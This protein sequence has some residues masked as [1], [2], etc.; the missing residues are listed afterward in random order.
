MSSITQ[1]T[2]ATY[3]A[4]L[5]Q[6][7]EFIVVDVETTHGD[8][9]RGS[10]I[11]VAVI[12]H[13][14]IRELDR[15]NTLVNTSAE[16]SPFIQKLTGITPGMLEGAPFFPTVAKSLHASTHGRIMVA[17]NVRYDM[18]ALQHELA[19]TGLSY[20]PDTLC[21]ERLCRQLVPNLNYYNLGSLSRYF[22]IRQGHKHRA[23][24]DAQAALELLLRL[25]NDH[26]QERVMKAVVPWVQ[27]ARA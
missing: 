20:Q 17:H 25:I 15:W 11:E 2:D 4:T 23:A 14:G 24:H 6:T 10:I 22:G 18:T 1:A 13:N 9:M 19:R 26:G 8:P 5:M 7:A 21:T 3:E 12:A 16:L 27:E